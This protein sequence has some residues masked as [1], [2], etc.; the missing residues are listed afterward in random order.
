MTSTT[1]SEIE[2]SGLSE[3]G[4]VREENQ[5][6][7]RLAEPH[8]SGSDGLL[9]AL[10]DGMG[11][12]AHGG[13]AS[14]LALQTFFETFY[15]ERTPM[16][17]KRL[18]R[19]IE[20]ANLAVY[21]A[22]QRMGVGR[23]GTTLTGLALFGNMLHIAHVGDSRAYLIRDGRT[24]CLTNDHTM[25]GDLVRMKVLS[26]DKVRT[27]AQRSVLNKALGLALFVHP[28]IT[29]LPLR[30]N[31]R[32]IVC[33]DGIWAAIED[34]EFGQ[35]AMAARSPQELCRE[36]V[37]LALARESDDNVSAIALHIRHIATAPLEKAR[38]AAGP[39]RFLRNPFAGGPIAR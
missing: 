19:G 27:H 29:E 18:R 15:D 33:S 4:H 12:Y 16:A 39:L 36:L 6:A 13:V 9:Y 30:A 3:V 26:P 11:G 17:S 8:R 21:Q 22:A 2:A 28:E 35:V 14:S 24:T 34:Q 7:I 23:M 10:A 38:N 1:L 20:S 37:D 32:L 25:V 5:D 31:D